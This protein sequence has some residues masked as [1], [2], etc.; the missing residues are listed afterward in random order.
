MGLEAVPAEKVLEH[1]KVFGLDLEGVFD[2]ILS[3]L[4]S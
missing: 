1:V 4:M 2:A 3:S